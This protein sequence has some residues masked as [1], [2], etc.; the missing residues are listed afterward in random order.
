M[1]VLDLLALFPHSLHQ[2]LSPVSTLHMSVF[3]QLLHQ[4][5]I[6]KPQLPKFLILNFPLQLQLPNPQLHH[7]QPLRLLT[8]TLHKLINPLIQYTLQSCAMIDLIFCE[9]LHSFV[10]RVGDL[11]ELGF[12]DLVPLLLE[13]GL[14]LLLAD[15][16]VL[17]DPWM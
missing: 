7:L 17:G 3:S 8:I 5:L 15:V 11:G 13:L 6:F 9:G 16:V 1:H 12:D 4:P 2:S 14:A 10:G